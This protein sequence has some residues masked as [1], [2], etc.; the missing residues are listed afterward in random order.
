MNCLC[1]NC[2][3][4]LINENGNYYSK[5]PVHEKEHTLFTMYLSEA[6]FFFS[7]EAA[8]KHIEDNKISG[9]TEVSDCSI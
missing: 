1:D 7:K 5:Y 3:W 6:T 4:L 9:V 2:L 8:K